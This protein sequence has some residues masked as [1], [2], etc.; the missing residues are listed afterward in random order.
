MDFDD[1][2]VLV[3]VQCVAIAAIEWLGTLNYGAICA[4]ILSSAMCMWGLRRKE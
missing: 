4:C 3:A 2:L 1:L